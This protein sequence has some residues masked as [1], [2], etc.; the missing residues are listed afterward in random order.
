MVCLCSRRVRDIFLRNEMFSRVVYP[1][2]FILEGDHVTFF[3]TKVCVRYVWCEGHVGLSAR[4]WCSRIRGASHTASS[5]RYRH[6]SLECQVPCPTRR[7]EPSPQDPVGLSWFFGG[8]PY[9]PS[10]KCRRVCPTYRFRR[11]TKTLP[12]FPS[13]GYR[14]E[15]NY[16]EE[17][18]LPCPLVRH[19]TGDPFPFAD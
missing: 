19:Q 2:N 1:L 5:L 8:E 3:E 16:K 10:L 11:V 12:R 15:G 4:N 17:G 9:R 6:P 13:S 18:P 7:H 14:T